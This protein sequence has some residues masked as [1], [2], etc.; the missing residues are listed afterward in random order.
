MI[1]QRPRGTQDILPKDSALWQQVEAAAREVCTLYGYQEIRTPIFEHTELF[2]RGVGETTDIVEKEMYTFLDKGN[3]SL[4]LRPEGTAGVARAFLENNLYTEPQPT[5]V[6]YIGPM[7]RY[8]RPG[9]GRLRQFHQFGV[10]AFGAVDPALDAEVI[11]LLFDFYQKAGL[12]DLELLLNSVGCPRCRPLHRKALKDY[13]SPR[14]DELCP[15]CQGRY[16]KNPL[17]ILDCKSAACQEIAADAPKLTEYLCPDCAAHFERT[18]AYLTEI[19]MNYTVDPGLV[20]GLDYYTNTA[21]E[22]I[23]KNGTLGSLGGGGRYNGL[24]EEI[25]GPPTP[26]IGFGVGLERA[27]LALQQQKSNFL[28]RQGPEIYLVTVGERAHLDGFGLLKILRDAG[29]RADQ[30]YLGKSVKGQLKAADRSQARFT[31]IIGEEEQEKGVVTVRDMAAGEQT[32]VSRTEL[33][34]YLRKTK[35]QADKE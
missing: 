32:A 26:G 16:Q 14:Y 8:G 29:Y 15:T 3:R 33:L 1:T 12:K 19:G 23:L 25:G 22:V 24:V 11:S 30:D 10:E 20:R 28:E 18:Q 21:F 35:E 13:L 5:K 6:F 7:F 27:L 34:A 31:L 2:T 17:R 9:S 4:T